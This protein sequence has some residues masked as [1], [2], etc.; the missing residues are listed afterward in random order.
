MLLCFCCCFVVVFV[1]CCFVVAFVVVLLLFCCCFVV[2]F[3]VVLLLFCCCFVVVL[4]LFLFCFVAVLF[5]CFVVVVFVFCCCC[6]L[7]VFVCFFLFLLQVNFTFIVRSAVVLFNSS[8]NGD[9]IA[10]MANSRETTKNCNHHQYISYVVLSLVPIPATLTSV[11]LWEGI[12]RG[13]G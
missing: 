5:C 1:F 12:G 4:L 2:A 9:E 10:A 7:L 6:Y 13:K 11:Q 3:V 8:S